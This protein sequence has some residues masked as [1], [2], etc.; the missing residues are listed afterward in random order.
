MIT[1]AGGLIAAYGA[2]HT[3]GALTLLGAATHA[4]TWFGRGLWGQSFE[5]MSPAMS[6]WWFSGDSFG[7]PLVALG[8]VVVWMGRRGITPPWFLTGILA[9]WW[10]LDAFVLAPSWNGLIPVAAIVLLVL[11]TLAG[12]RRA[13]EATP[14]Q[15]MS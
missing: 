14:V 4:D 7:V 10:A 1:W 12:R 8:L 13:R 2:L 5:E 15:L 9:A 6:A 3:I 11:G